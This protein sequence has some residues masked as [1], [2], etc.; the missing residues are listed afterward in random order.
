MAARRGRRWTRCPA[1]PARLEDATGLPPA[2]IEVGRLDVLRDEDL[3]YAANLSRA[4]VSEPRTSSIRSPSRPT[5]LT[6]LPPTASESA[7]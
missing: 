2:C 3:A 6:A 4:G 5:S 1:A 7:T